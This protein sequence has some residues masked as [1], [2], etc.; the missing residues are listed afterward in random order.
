MIRFTRHAS[1]K[2]LLL[3]L[4]NV[5]ISKRMVIRALTNPE[6]IDHS[7]SPLLIAQINFDK[8]RVLRVVYRQEGDTKV[9]ITFYPGRKS[10]YEK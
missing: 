5:A 7:R 8:M 9:V 4:H 2:F 1:E 10:Q 6:V 3:R